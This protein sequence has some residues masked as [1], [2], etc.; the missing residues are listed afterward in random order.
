MFARALPVHVGSVQPHVY[1]WPRNE[2]KGNNP[3]TITGRHPHVC[4][5][6]AR[7]RRTNKNFTHALHT[8]H[9]PRKQK[10]LRKHNSHQQQPTPTAVGHTHCIQSH[11]LRTQQLPEQITRHGNSGTQKVSH[12]NRGE[13]AGSKHHK[14]HPT[15]SSCLWRS[16][17]RGHRSADACVT[18]AQWSEWRCTRVGWTVH[19]FQPKTHLRVASL[20]DWQPRL[21][22]AIVRK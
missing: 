1:S 21:A 12:A 10:H 19:G 9:F 2:P 5:L 8:S 3:D 20:P 11:A 22:K 18:W 4:S 7:V 15:T 16:G 17:A 14:R 13:Q 6:S